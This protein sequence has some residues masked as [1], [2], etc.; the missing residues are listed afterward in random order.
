M[1]YFTNWNFLGSVNLKIAGIP[2][3]AVKR[4]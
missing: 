4:A 1:L 2:V 3:P